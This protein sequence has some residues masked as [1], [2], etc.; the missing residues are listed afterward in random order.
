MDALDLARINS[1]TTPWRTDVE[2]IYHQLMLDLPLKRRVTQ[3]YSRITRRSAAYIGGKVQL[4]RQGNARVERSVNGIHQCKYMQL[5]KK[6]NVW[7][8]VATEK[9]A[10]VKAQVQTNH[11]VKHEGL[12]AVKIKRPEVREE[13][14]VTDIVKVENKATMSEDEQNPKIKIESVKVDTGTCMSPMKN[15]TRQCVEE[16]MEVNEYGTKIK[17]KCKASP[18]GQMTAIKPKVEYKVGTATKREFR[19]GSFGFEGNTKNSRIEGRVMG[20]IKQDLE[21]NI[22]NKPVGMYS[23]I[24]RLKT[25]PELHDMAEKEEMMKRVKQAEED[26]RKVKEE[27]KRLKEEI[28]NLGLGM[29]GVDGQIRKPAAELVTSPVVPLEKKEAFGG[30]IMMD[31]DSDTDVGAILEFNKPRCLHTATQTDWVGKSQFHKATQFPIT[32]YSSDELRSMSAD[33]VPVK[34]ASLYSGEFMQ[35]HVA[36]QTEWLGHNTMHKAIQFPEVTY[37]KEEERPGKDIPSF[38]PAV[39]PHVPMIPQWKPIPEVAPPGV[40]ATAPTSTIAQT[41]PVQKPPVTTTPVTKT[42]TTRSDATAP[43]T[44]AAAVKQESDEESKDKIIIPKVSTSS[45]DSQ[46]VVQAVQSVVTAPPISQPTAQVVRPIIGAAGGFMYP[47]YAS[48]AMYT[49]MYNPTY[50]IPQ[51]SYPYQYVMMGGAAPPRPPG[52]PDGENSETK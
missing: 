32:H 14:T 1:R 20:T 33:L 41:P 42:T 16:N 43:T 9:L 17:A 34:K 52:P 19:G 25:E 31:I 15:G 38:I 45:S 2:D 5:V 40:P 8:K 22:V 29:C 7:V 18:E 51:Y 30:G 3:F 46:T 36:T 28:T 48:Q 47:Q 37:C 12:T 27:N 23:V 6:L 13:A 21:G 10:L 4:A 11:A 49:P 39:N 50:Y 35:L 26:A 24:Q 44:S